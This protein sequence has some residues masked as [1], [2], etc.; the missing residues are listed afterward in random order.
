MKGKVLDLHAFG[1][2]FSDELIGHIE[3]GGW[4]GGG[5]IFFGPDGLVALDV[6]FSGVA[7]HVWWERDVAVLLGNLVERSIA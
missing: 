2:K 3:A 5:A 1:L 7:V 6:G 4:C